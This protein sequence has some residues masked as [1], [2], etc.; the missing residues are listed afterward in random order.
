M[1]YCKVNSVPKVPCIPRIIDRACKLCGIIRRHDDAIASVYVV[2]RAN[3]NKA[4]DERWQSWHRVIVMCDPEVP[5]EVLIRDV[6]AHGQTANPWL[7]IGVQI[8]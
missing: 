5:S 4:E 1:T 8:A 2:L 7:P 3:M 6:I